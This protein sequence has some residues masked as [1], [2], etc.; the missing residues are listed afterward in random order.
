MSVESLEGRKCYEFGAAPGLTA[1]QIEAMLGQLDDG[2]KVVDVDGSNRI[3]REWK[4][5]DFMTVRMP[6]I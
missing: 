3:R 4:V 6:D 5:K 1:E 2:W